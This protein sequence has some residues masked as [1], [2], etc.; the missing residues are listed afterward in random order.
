MFGR[1]HFK[2]EVNL[3][4]RFTDLHLHDALNIFV[5]FNGRDSEIKKTSEGAGGGVACD[6]CPPSSTLSTPKAD[7]Y[8][9]NQKT[10]DLKLG[11]TTG[12]SL[13]FCP[14]HQPP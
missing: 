13:P 11:S 8:E 2:R 4:T 1:V 3:I 12:F 14:S 10:L 5:F 6:V 7:D 9:F